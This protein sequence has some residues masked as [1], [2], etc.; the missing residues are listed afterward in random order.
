MSGRRWSNV[1]VCAYVCDN[2]REREN[3]VGNGGMRLSSE[4][5]RQE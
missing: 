4:L 5:L 2:E 3:D 1:C